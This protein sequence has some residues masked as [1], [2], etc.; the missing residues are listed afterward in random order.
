MNRYIAL[1]NWTDQGIRSVKD[2]PKR[3]DA[4]RDLAQKLGGKL[5]EFYLTMGTYDMVVVLDAPDDETVAKFNLMIG[6]G[7]NLRT[8]T[9][10]AF[11]EADYRKIFNAL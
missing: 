3:L 11:G 8:V 9:L 10:K 7:G 2:S 1:C 5:V 6:M 4:A